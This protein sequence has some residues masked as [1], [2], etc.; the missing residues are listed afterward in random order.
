[1]K[2]VV[3]NLQLTLDGFEGMPSVQKTQSSE[4]PRVVFSSACYSDGI[5]RSHSIPKDHCRTYEVVPG[6]TTKDLKAQV[7]LR[8]PNRIR[9]MI[10]WHSLQIN[11]SMNQVVLEI[12]FEADNREGWEEPPAEFAALNNQSLVA[13]RGKWKKD[14]HGYNTK[15]LDASMPIR[16]PEDL[17]LRLKWRSL[18]IRK[19][20]V[21]II[22]T[23]VMDRIVEEDWPEAPDWCK[24]AR[25]NNGKLRLA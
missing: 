6:I 13:V 16:M 10:R 11:Y 17:Y 14:V 19:S 2:E 12:L 9:D 20:V 21:E 5:D 3:S 24:K 22:F 8:C 18:Q 23:N 7:Q 1:M 4:V 25:R 15:D